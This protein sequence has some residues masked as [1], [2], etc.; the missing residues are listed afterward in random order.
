MDKLTRRNFLKAGAAGAAT[1]VLT[2]CSSYQRYVTLEPYVRAPEEQLNGVPTFYASTCRMCPAGCG[3]I[4]RVMNGRALKVEGNPQH[5]LNRGKLCPRGQ[6]G[7][8]LLYNPD[9]FPGP[10]QQEK[11]NPDS[12]RSLTW[13]QAIDTLASQLQGAGGGV[14]VWGSA[15]MSGHLYDLFGRLL[16]A[17]G[18]SGAPLIYDLF[19]GVNG[20]AVQDKADEQ[21]FGQAALPVYDLANADVVLSFSSNLLGPSPSQ[22]RYGVDYGTFRRRPGGLRGVLVQFEPRMSITG[23]K[24]DRWFAIRPG[25]EALIAQALL[26]IIA[27]QKFGPADRVSRAGSLAGS[28]DLNAVAAASDISIESLTNVAR[29]F[30]TAAHPVAIAGAPLTGQPN[31]LQAFSAVHALN[32]VAGAVGQVGGVSLSVPAPIAQTV[33]PAANSYTDALQLIDRMRRGEI[34]VLMIHDGN[35]LYVLPPKAGFAE[36]IKNV[37]FVVSFASLPDD[38]S[39]WADL[40]LPDRTYLESWGYEVVSPSFGQPVIGS[41]QPVVTGVTNLDPRATADVLLAVAQKIPAA[42]SAIPFTDEVAFL[43]DIV[44]ALGPGAAGG[45]GADVLWAKFLQTGGWW[46][47]NP[48]VATPLQ[49]AASGP[50]TVSPVQFNGDANTYPFYLHLFLSDLLSDTRE[51]N[52]PWL[53]GA[54]DPMTTIAWQTWVEINPQTARQLK[55]NI[56]DI[57]KVTSPEGEI[58]AMVYTT[59]AIRPDTVAVAFGQGHVNTGRYATGGNRSG[60]AMHLVGAQADSSSGGFT[61]ANLRAK[62]TPTGRRVDPATFEWTEGVRRGFENAGQ[63][64]VS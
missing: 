35:P 38:T 33:K 26:R 7:P 39:A 22:T 37:P 51:A 42:K 9:R 63:P 5:P 2:G 24:S 21:L 41:Q 32:I 10:R 53:Q 52:I 16:K 44:N 25:S 50:V 58:E 30:A 34:K 64:G 17:L 1:A 47:A 11:G 8:Q 49:V 48:P 3:I 56:G 46:Q 19:S 18:A 36:A 43:K 14:A 13:D 57:V 29:L 40:I 31:A 54:P 60:N 27:D 20:Y 6:A 28:V 59:P 15:V 62:I 61:W 12:F 55:L 4:V 45:T 23:V